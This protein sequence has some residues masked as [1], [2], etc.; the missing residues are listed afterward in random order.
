MG[1]AE[2]GEQ[3]ARETFDLVSHDGGTDAKRVEPVE[4]RDDAR[5]GAAVDR[6]MRFVKAQ[7][8]GIEPLDR[9]IGNTA[10]CAQPLLEHMPRPASDPRPH[11]S[12]ER[13]V[14]KECV[15]TCRS[16]WPPYP[17]KKN[18]RQTKYHEVR[19]VKTVN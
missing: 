4:R 16:R 8:F 15:S 7:Q 12:E 18:P 19:Y 11:R 17:Y 9:A 10:R 14:G 13:R 5:K 1:E 6:D 3:Q 2:F